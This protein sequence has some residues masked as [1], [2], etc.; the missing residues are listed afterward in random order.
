MTTRAL[1]DAVHTLISRFEDQSETVAV[2]VAGSTVTGQADAASDIDVYLFV[3]WD[4]PL[5]ARREIL[6]PIDPNAAIGN[7]WF[8]D[9]DELVDPAS[10]CVI[11]LVYFATD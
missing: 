8:G 6:T 3:S 7:D 5:E 4:I 2:T 10:G 9:N 1:P 11:D